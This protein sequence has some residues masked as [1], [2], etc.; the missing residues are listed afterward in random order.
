VHAIPI[1]AL[2]NEYGLPAYPRRALDWDIVREEIS[3]G[4]P[5]IAWIIGGS[6][7]SLANGIPRYY[8]AN[9]TGHHSVVGAYEHTVIVTGYTETQVTVLNGAYFVTL[10]LD[11]FLDSWSALWNSAVLANP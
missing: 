8:T 7:Y 4:D 5:V 6:N 10:S 1:A 2:L 9:S 11:Q 3:N